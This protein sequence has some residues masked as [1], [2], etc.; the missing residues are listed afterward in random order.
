MRIRLKGMT[1][2]YE[3]SFISKQDYINFYGIQQTLTDCYDCHVN[4]TLEFIYYNPIGFFDNAPITSNSVQGQG[5]RGE[6]ATG[7]TIGKKTFSFSFDGVN[8][9][10]Y[11]L[12]PNSY[13]SLMAFETYE[14]IEL[15]VETIE[16]S[17]KLLCVFGDNTSLESEGIE[18]Y[19]ADTEEGLFWK[20]YYSGDSDKN[21]HLNEILYLY[22]NESTIPLSIPKTFDDEYG[23]D[24]TFDLIGG[25]ELNYEVGGN[26]N[27]KWEY[28]ILTQNDSHS[29]RIDN[30]YNDRFIKINSQEGKIVNENGEDREDCVTTLIGDRKIIITDPGMNHFHTEWNHG[31]YFAYPTDFYQI[32]SLEQTLPTLP[33]GSTKC[34]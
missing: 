16:Y 7:Q 26:F 13:I 23:Y 24:I 33:G 2:G 14:Y 17:A 11:N 29:W 25:Q 12:S 10:T 3:V 31:K 27:G 20:I 21:T 18:L 1:T 28:V 22:N 15:T 4:E 6:K 19:S 34:Q 8:S 32:F 9:R 5:Q 30:K